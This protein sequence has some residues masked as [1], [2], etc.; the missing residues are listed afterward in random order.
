MV[1]FLL[2]FFFGIFGAHRFYLGQRGKGIAMLSISLVALMATINGD[3]PL[4]AVMG[5]IA[6]I[7]SIILL[8]MPRSEFHQKYNSPANRSV[9]A[10]ARKSKRKS[11]T[12]TRKP[13]KT[14]I[15][16]V[17][18]DPTK[19]LFDLGVREY[20]KGRYNEA[21]EK[22]DQV[23]HRRP[24]DYLAHFYLARI[25]TLMYDSQDAFYHLEKSIEF[26]FDD[27]E[28]L[29]ED[30]ALGFLRSHKDYAAFKRN[31]YKQHIVEREPVTEEEDVNPDPACR[32]SRSSFNIRENRTTWRSHGKGGDYPG[33]I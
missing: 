21:I 22:F 11:R 29:D 23:L 20:K 7:D 28:W 16:S 3:V 10:S 4:I 32:Y 9:P 6:F 25:F 24:G 14:S 19:R 33:S 1:A 5:I 15:P 30:P 2:A 13:V 31:G 26:G 27:F 17:R 8:A 12:K 18:E